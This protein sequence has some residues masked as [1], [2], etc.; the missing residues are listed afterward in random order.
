MALSVYKVDQKTRLVLPDTRWAYEVRIRL[1]AAGHQ[2][3]FSG[4]DANMVQNT[5]SV[6]ELSRAMD[7]IDSTGL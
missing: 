3:E 5:R 6:D 4:E 2:V 1:A 7:L